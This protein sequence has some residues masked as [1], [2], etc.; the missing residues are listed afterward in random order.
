MDAE[1]TFRVEPDGGRVVLVPEFWPSDLDADARTAYEGLRTLH[2][3]EDGAISMPAEYLPETE[4]GSTVTLSAVWTARTER[5][6]ALGVG[7]FPAGA[8]GG[9]MADRDRIARTLL[10]DDPGR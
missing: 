4:P 10:D 7:P 6:G 5:L 8:V 1:A 9:A 3:V 2:V